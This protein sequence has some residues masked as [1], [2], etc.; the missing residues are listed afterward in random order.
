[1]TAPS[2]RT[3]W[4]YVFLLTIILGAVVFARLCEW[5]GR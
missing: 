4:L 5:V 2:A 1:M 3:F